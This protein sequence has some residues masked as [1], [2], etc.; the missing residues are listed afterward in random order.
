M[1]EITENTKLTDID[2]INI[3]QSLPLDEKIEQYL[4]E[5]KDPY[6]HI[7]QGYVVKVSYSNTDYTATDA[8]KNYLRQISNLKY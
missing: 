5:T 3:N 7:N 4:M 2:D 8:L 6:T 1:F